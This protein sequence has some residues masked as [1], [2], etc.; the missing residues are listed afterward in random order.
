MVLGTW[1]NTNY[2][3]SHP[4]DLDRAIDVAQYVCDNSTNSRTKQHVSSE[5]SA[6]TQLKADIA[7]GKISSK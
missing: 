6:L 3:A 5:L 4:A 2:Y 7:A 1:L